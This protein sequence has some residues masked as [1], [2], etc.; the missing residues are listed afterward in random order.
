MSSKML[1]YTVELGQVY[2]DD[3]D[4]DTDLTYDIMMPA[5]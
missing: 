5:K 4:H 2:G 3:N 1:R